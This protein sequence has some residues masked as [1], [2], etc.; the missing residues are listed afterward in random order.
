MH[1]TL[2]DGTVGGTVK[3]KTGF[4]FCQIAISGRNSGVVTLMTQALGSDVFE[5]LDPP[6]TF[7]LA[8]ERTH[9][10]PNAAH[11]SLHLAPDVPGDD[12][13]VTITQWGL[14]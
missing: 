10:I 5:H 8:N 7:N 14:N 13:T 1:E 12:F 6:M 9:I 11:E 4:H 3:V 2:L